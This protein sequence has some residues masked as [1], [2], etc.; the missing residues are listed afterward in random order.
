MY[1]SQTTPLF[2]L[3]NKIRGP[4]YSYELKG[5]AITD[6]LSDMP[7]INL[8]QWRFGKERKDM[9]AMGK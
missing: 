2:S 3:P 7:A 8:V 9:V 1:N 5:I 4:D 6:A